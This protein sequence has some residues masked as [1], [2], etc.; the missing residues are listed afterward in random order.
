M[1]NIDLHS[2]WIS[3][4]TCNADTTITIV[5]NTNTLQDVVISLDWDIEGIIENV[6]WFIQKY[7]NDSYLGSV[8]GEQTGT[9]TL[10]V[11]PDSDWPTEGSWIEITIVGET[12]ASDYP[13]ETGP[14]TKIVFT[15]KSGNTT[16][17]IQTPIGGL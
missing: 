3:D 9:D 11:S 5:D 12:D 14:G 13:T 7:R 8:E 6:E 16:C 15:R 1:V 2:P 17:L 10:T 4:P